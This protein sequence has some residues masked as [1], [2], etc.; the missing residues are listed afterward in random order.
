MSMATVE[1]RRAEVAPL[2]EMKIRGAG[3]GDLQDII[4][5]YNA[6]IAT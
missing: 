4:R 5:I 2:G 1:E 6:A 3:E